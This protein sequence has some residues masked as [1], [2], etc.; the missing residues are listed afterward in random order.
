MTIKEIRGMTGL[1]QTKFAQRYEIPRNTIV[2][3]EQGY[4]EP[5]AYVLKLLEKVVRMD[6]EN[7]KEEIREKVMR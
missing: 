1:S 7:E 3:W 2:S 4:R 5:P 6:V